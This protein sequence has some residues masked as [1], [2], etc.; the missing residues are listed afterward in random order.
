MSGSQLIRGV[1]RTVTL[2]LISDGNDGSTARQRTHPRPLASLMTS[3]WCARIGEVPTAAAGLTATDVVEACGVRVTSKVPNGKT[4]RRP[5]LLQARKRSTFVER[6]ANEDTLASGT[7]LPL[8]FTLGSG[9]AFCCASVGE[10]ARRETRQRKSALLAPP[11]NKRMQLTKRTAAGGARVRARKFIVRPAQTS[12]RRCKSSRKQAIA[13]EAKRNCGRATDRGKEAW[14][15]AAGR[16]TGTGSEAASSVASQQWTA[17]PRWPKLRRRKSGGRAAK[18]DVFTW[19][20]LVSC[21]KGR[22]QQTGGTR[23]QPRP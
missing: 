12:R 16:P 3:A 20:A 18:G 10:V 15:E 9:S 7:M 23:S 6:R 21:L 8:A 14:S 22:R 2:C 4:Q 11:S 1:G 19:G 5:R 13:N 17:K